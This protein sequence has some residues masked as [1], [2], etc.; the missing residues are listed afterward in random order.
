MS[1]AV[2]SPWDMVLTPEASNAKADPTCISAC[3]LGDLWFLKCHMAG[4]MPTFLFSNSDSFC[5]PVE[6][7]C[8]R[9]SSGFLH[10]YFLQQRLKR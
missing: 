10:F 9:V 7:S 8:S 3:P 4:L 1:P 6:I 2:H 5:F